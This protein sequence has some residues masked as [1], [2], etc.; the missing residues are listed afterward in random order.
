MGADVPINDLGEMMR[1]SVFA[2]VAG[3]MPGFNSF[4]LQPGFDEIAP[5]KYIHFFWVLTGCSTFDEWEE[6]FDWVIHVVESDNL[7]AGWTMLSVTKPRDWQRLCIWE[8]NSPKVLAT[9]R[10]WRTDS[11]HLVDMPKESEEK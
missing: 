3:K 6:E 7:I 1:G 10:P 8:K 9:F 11:W 4:V 5:N 2:P